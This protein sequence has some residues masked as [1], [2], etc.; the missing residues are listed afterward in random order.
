LADGSVKPVHF[1]VDLALPQTAGDN[2][3]V[4]A[5]KIKDGNYFWHGLL[6]EFVIGGCWQARSEVKH[7]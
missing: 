1:R 7:F 2:L 3:G 6:S 5:S 4:L